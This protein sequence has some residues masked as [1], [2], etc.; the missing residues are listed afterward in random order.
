[1][2]NKKVSQLTSKP[3][4][5]VTDLFPIADP[6]TGQLFK[7]TISALGTAIGSGVSSV[8]TLVGAV[9][10]DTD[11]I[12]ELAS[13]TNRWYTD[14]RSRA[15]L[16][17]VSPLVYN[18]GTGAFS[19]PAAT[20]SVNG[21]LTSTDWTTF[22]AKQAAL[23]GTGFVKISG[24]TISY[25]NSTYLTTSA[26]AS[27]YLALAGGT[28]TGALNGT[29]ANFSG[30]LTLTGTNPRFYLTDSDNNPDYFISNTDGTFTVYDVTNSVSRFTIGTTGNGTFGG[31]LTVGQ[32][33][34]S[35]GTSSQFLKADGSV[36]S[37]AYVRGSGAIGYYARF[38]S[39]GIISDGFINTDS[40]ITYVSGMGL[41]TLNGIDI[42]GNF[43]A[44][45]GGLKI[46]SFD[47]TT[48]KAYINF[49]NTDGVFRLGIEGSTGGGIL[50][51]STAYATVFTSGLTG[52]NL[53]FGTNNAKRLTLDGTTG[54]A[55]FTSTISA[56]GATLT[57]A[58][59]GTSATFVA[60]STYTNFLIGS[61]S[62]TGAIVV[63]ANRTN[64]VLGAVTSN[65]I[66]FNN[67]STTQNGYI[68]SDSAELSLGYPASGT[69]N[70]QKS[71]VGNV[72]SIASSGAATFSSSVTAGGKLTIAGGGTNNILVSENNGAVTI[73]TNGLSINTGYGVG[74]IEN[75][76]GGNYADLYYSASKHL[77][78]AGFVGIGTTAP[79]YPLTVG[80]ANS[81]AD[82]Y[83]QIAST[84]TGTGNLFF[85]DTTGQGTG[86]YMGYLQYQ[87]NVDAMI[88]ATGANERMRIT[89]GGNV[90]IGTTAPSAII[91]GSETTLNV[92]GNV[93]GAV[94]TIV[95][96]SSGFS[97]TTSIGIA[98]FDSVNLTGIYVET[99]SPMAF[100]TNATE[101]MRITSGGNVLIGQTTASGSSNGIYFR[102]GIESGIIVTSDIAL[103]LG[104][105]GTTGDIQSFY[106]GST[107]VGTIS[108][109]GSATSYNTTSDYRLKQDLKEFNG[110][111][112]VN[113]I[114]VYDYE[115]KADN[116]R[117]YGVLAHELQEVLSYAVMGEKDAATM[118]GVDYSKL[119][120]ILVQ[121]IKEL[122][123]KIETLENK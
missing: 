28:L 2:A 97:N 93:S 36:D 31:N 62:T 65:K 71:G 56:N 16:S 50:P 60:S 40:N 44:G 22:N 32:I 10:L 88:F 85:G 6:T 100:W 101:R 8:N 117:S 51:G 86:S 81:T 38:T 111:E 115:W 39:S 99:N 61:T 114:K 53:E 69:F 27:T 80:Q 122:K 67:A 1:M 12:Q 72:F 33:I 63:D 121:A 21:Y 48:G 7:T 5:L 19:I 45:T 41:S 84:T 64:L 105:L 112:V 96:R 3:S 17:A 18:S 24:T 29:S 11:D 59:S 47:E 55:T 120:P 108:V 110:L 9:V 92:K 106:T 83:I 73:P 94:G 103:Q 58:L 95:A 109:S 76:N 49:I 118:Q 107:R 87:H 89:S 35:G 75:R 14:T 13:P 91:S 15:A 68:Y 116:T 79:S 104:R 77:F 78:T 113:K 23:S 90:G 57:G 37:T 46:R 98:A 54:A 70:V 123:A 30:D 119:T 42:N 82:S 66:V 34:R 52:K 26:A 25:D 43:G 4:V 102:A 74:Y 20:T